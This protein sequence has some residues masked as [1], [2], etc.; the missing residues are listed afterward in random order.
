MLSKY[1]P[2]NRLWLPTPVVLTTVFDYYLVSEGK[3]RNI[4]LRNMTKV[5]PGPDDAGIT[6]V[7]ELYTTQ[8]GND[9]LYQLS[10]GSPLEQD[11]WIQRIE[12][13]SALGIGRN[14]S[15]RLNILFVTCRGSGT[16]D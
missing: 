9:M 14:N 13:T 11:E 2:V 3:E 8:Q 16:I 15:K 6:N 10:L 12:D 1:Q 5:W 4:A 7:F